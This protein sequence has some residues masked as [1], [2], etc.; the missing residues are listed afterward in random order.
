MFHDFWERTSY[1]II[2]PL[3]DVLET[4]G[5]LLVCRA[6]RGMPQ[7]AAQRLVGGGAQ[8]SGFRV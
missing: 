7:E 2:L 3:V 4:A 8:G 1:H 5:E 6:K